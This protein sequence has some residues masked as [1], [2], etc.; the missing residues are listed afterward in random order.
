MIRFFS[1]CDLLPELSAVNI[2]PTDEAEHSFHFLQHDRALIAKATVANV[3]HSTAVLYSGTSVRERPCSRTI[4]FT[5][6]FSEQK[7]LGLRTRKLATDARWAYRRGCV[8]CWLTNLVSVYE[9]F[10][11]RMA[12]RNKLSL[13]TKVPLYLMYWV[14]VVGVCVGVCGSMCV[15]AAYCY[16]WKICEAQFC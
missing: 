15:W 12:S 7:R 5:N 10:G 9:H 1:H 3:N 13:W 6:K 14:V 11:S 4:R 16:V 8:S 2:P